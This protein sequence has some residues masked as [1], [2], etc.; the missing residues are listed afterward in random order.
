MFNRPNQMNILFIHQNFPGQYKFLSPALAARGHRVEAMGISERPDMG[1]VKYHR[2]QTAKKN[3]PNIHPWVLDFETKVIR[4]EYCIRA[5]S[6][7]A[8]SGFTPDVICAHPGWGESLFLKELWP[9]AKQLHYVEYFYNAEGQD[10]GFDSQFPTPGLGQKCRLWTK[11]ANNLMNLVQMDQ[12]VSPTAWQHASIPAAFKEKIA[13]IHDGIDT[14][15][16]NASDDA[17]LKATDDQGRDISFTRQDEVV[18]FVNRN[19]EPFRGY[20]IF[21]QALPRMMKERPNAHFVLIGGDSVSYGAAPKEGSWKQIYLD[22]VKAELDLSRL[23]FLGRVP[24][25]TYVSAMQVSKAHVYLTYPFVLS[26]SLLE[27]MAMKVPI[28]A[29]STAPVMEVVKDGFNGHLVDFFDVNALVNKVIQVLEKPE[30]Q[31]EMRENARRT[32][33]EKYDLMTQCLPAHIQL[34]ESLSPSKA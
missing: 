1:S 23:H 27:C 11:N 18:T 2:Y 9:Q 17:V 29:S 3:T 31:T 13:V 4:G 26:W 30:L 5:A 14:R 20:H 7:L 33:V 19:L 15:I 32:I 34:V 16:L 6:Q 12:G 10:M 25:A 22:Q 21:M 28:I 24:Y 8:D